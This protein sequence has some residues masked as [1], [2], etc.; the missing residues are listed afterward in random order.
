M[1]RHP[2]VVVDSIVADVM[3]VC[4]SVRTQRDGYRPQTEHIALATL[5]RT[6]FPA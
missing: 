3:S 4:L 6:E 5:R 2:F 1:Q